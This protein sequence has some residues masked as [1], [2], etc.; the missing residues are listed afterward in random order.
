MLTPIF[1]ELCRDCEDAWPPESSSTFFMTAK[2]LHRLAGLSYVAVNIPDRVAVGSFNH[3]LYS[4]GAVVWKR[5]QHPLSAER[6]SGL[7]L[8]PDSRNDRRPSEWFARE[9]PA[10]LDGKAGSKA[11]RARNTR[12]FSFPLTPRCGETAVFAFSIDAANTQGSD[13]TGDRQAALLIGDMRVLAQYFHKHVLRLNGNGSA[14]D[15]A[16]SGRELDCLK[17]TAAGKTAWEASVILGISERTV[18]FHLNAAREK[19]KCTTTT[20]AVAKA[21]AQ[22]LI[23][24]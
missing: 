21:V 12:S 11:V 7:G 14:A 5:S 8:S 13:E 1:E 23:S 3:C 6:L 20:Q 19:M 10:M 2:L 24:C 4:D 18:R 16:I 9:Q 15:L 17:W 22:D